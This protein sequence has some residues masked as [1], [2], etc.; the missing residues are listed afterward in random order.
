MTYKL[1]TA[2]AYLG[3]HKE[4]A[5]NPPSLPLPS[6]PLSSLPSPPLPSP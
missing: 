3:F 5:S 4:G 6:P 2:V 1:P